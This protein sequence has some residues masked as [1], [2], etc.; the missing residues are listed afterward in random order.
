MTFSGRRRSP[1]GWWF[2]T[3]CEIEFLRGERYLPDLAG[4][5]IDRVPQLPT[6]TRISIPPQWVC[7]I[8]SPSTAH[9]DLGEKQQ[10]YHAAH[11]EH[12]WHLDPTSQSLT[13][14]GWDED[15]YRPLLTAEAGDVV[16]AEPFDAVEFDL[17]ELFEFD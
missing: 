9:R 15:S 12:Y 14:L 13:V 16:R 6:N 1:G 8:L 4:W 10:T 7:E 3:E 17:G 5:R 2:G 11:V